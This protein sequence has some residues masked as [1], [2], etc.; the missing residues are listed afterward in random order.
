MRLSGTFACLFLAA[1]LIAATPGY[2]HG[3]DRAFA[4]PQEVFRV[5]PGTFKPTGDFK[6]QRGMFAVGR[7]TF[8]P[9]GGYTTPK[10]TYTASPDTFRVHKGAFSVKGNFRVKPGAY[11]ISRNFLN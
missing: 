6:V 3:G 8:T 9:T 4:G 2:I 10:H 11:S 7:R 5:V 1:P